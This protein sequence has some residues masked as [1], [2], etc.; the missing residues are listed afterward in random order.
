MPEA[1]SCGARNKA[2]GRRGPLSRHTLVL[3]CNDHGL[4]ETPGRRSAR[5]GEARIRDRADLYTCARA[6]Y[7]LSKSSMAE[8]ARREGWVKFRCPQEIERQLEHDIRVE[9]QATEGAAFAKGLA[10]S[11]RATVRRR[12]ASGR[13]GRAP[14]RTRATKPN[15]RPDTT[16]LTCNRSSNCQSAN[17]PRCRGRRYRVIG[18]AGRS[19]PT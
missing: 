4:S 12:Q 17:F 9:A 8:W 1:V 16:S 18:L 2:V 19:R 14:A 13:A 3:Y 10:R 7:G 6:K 11:L 5:G 15:R